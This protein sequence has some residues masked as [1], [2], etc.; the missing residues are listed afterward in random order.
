MG[1]SYSNIDMDAVSETGSGDFVYDIAEADAQSFIL[2]AGV[3]YAQPLDWGGQGAWFLEGVARYE[4]DALA[5]DD[6]AHEVTA[7]NAIFGTFTQVGQNRGP[8]HLQIGLGLSYQVSDTLRANAGYGYGY[9]GNGDEHA[10]T[11]NLR[12]DW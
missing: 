5:N 10:L 7:S 3:D 9:N 12:M 6:S 1:I 2:S 8:H 11:A 4:F